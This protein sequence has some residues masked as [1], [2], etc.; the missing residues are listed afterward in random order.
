MHFRWDQQGPVRLWHYLDE[1]L[2]KSGEM[3]PTKMRLSSLWIAVSCRFLVDLRCIFMY[4][5]GCKRGAEG[6]GCS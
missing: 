5:Y 4:C 6:I 3:L 2:R 1:F